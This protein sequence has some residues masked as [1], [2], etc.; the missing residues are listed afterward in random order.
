MTQPTRYATATA[1][2]QAVEARLMNLARAEQVDI[3]RL[4]RQVA[5]DRL[6]CRLF[7]NP[8]APWALKG[9]YAMELRMAMARTTRDIDLS[10]RQRIAGGKKALNR[11][12]GKTVS[13]PGDGMRLETRPSQ[14]PRH[15]K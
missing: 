15:A 3:Q 7:H 12:L 4:R 2:R 13:R 6:L 5:F 9:G 1:F 14:S 8:Q 11:K 10:V